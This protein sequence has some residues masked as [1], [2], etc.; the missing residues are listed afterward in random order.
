MQPSF[1]S[2]SPSAAHVFSLFNVSKFTTL[3]LYVYTR[4]ARPQTNVPLGKET[5]TPREA[6]YAVTQRN[7]EHV[8]QP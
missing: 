2:C 8:L 3:Y 1:A 6:T 4:V 5:R 7:S